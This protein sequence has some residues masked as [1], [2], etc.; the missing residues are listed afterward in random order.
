M[1]RGQLLTYY[2]RELRYLRE[3]G[4]QFADKYPRIA[5]R[6]M[7]EKGKC[8]DPHVERLLE[9]FAFLSARIHLK[10]N[11]DFPLIAEGILNTVYPHFLRPIPSMSV[12]EVELDRNTGK[13]TGKLP[14]KAGAILYSKPVDGVNCKFRTAY[15]LELWPISVAFAEWTSPERLRPA[16]RAIE[17][18]HAIRI[19]INAFPDIELGKIGLDR[20]RFYLHGEEGVVHALYEA[21][22]SKLVRII[23]RE[24]DVKG[25]TVDLSPLHLQPLGLEAPKE[26]PEQESNLEDFVEPWLLPYQG[27]S[28]TAYRLLQE[29]FTFPQKFFFIEVKGLREIFGQGFKHQAELILLLGQIEGD[30]RRKRMESITSSTFRLGCSPVVNLFEHTCEPIRLDHRKCEYDLRLSRR[31]HAYEIFSIRQVL[32][33]D[34]GR[35]IHREYQPF[36]SVRRNGHGEEPQIFWVANSRSTL[37]S[38]DWATDTYLSFMDLSSR[39]LC[40]PV[41]SVTVKVFAT[42]RDLPAALTIGNVQGDLDLE[43]SAPIKRIAMLLQPTTPYRPPFGVASHWRLISHLS[44]NY[45]SLVSEGKEALQEILRLYN[46]SESVHQER[47]IQGIKHLRSQRGFARLT[48]EEGIAFARGWNVE[49]ELDEEQ[50]VG[51]GAYLFSAVLERFLASYATLNS[52]TQLRVRSTQR[53]EVIEEWE[54]RAGQKILV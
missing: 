23:V 6:L 46:F 35:E 21:L 7:L 40:P 19:G 53:R 39:P 8:E 18:A 16:L 1:T 17:A 4:A 45:L 32:S 14:I 31:P 49:I 12:V 50:F 28:F 27:R 2:E 29:F 52:Y 5:G 11:D 37:S 38:E 34:V 41:E 47:M 3:V 13:L 26:K 48:S 33:Q 20:L 42:N 9:A 15:D 54:P 22:C 25:P 36:Y 10:L 30:D 51:G 24:A 43:V 44:L